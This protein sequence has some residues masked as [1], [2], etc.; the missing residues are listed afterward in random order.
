[1]PMVRLEDHGGGRLD[2]LYCKY[3]TDAQ[4]KLKSR[5]EVRK[6]MIDFAVA[7]RRKSIEDAEKFVEKF[8]RKMPAWKE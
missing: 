5:E 8:M 1:M 4:G 6:S 2:I 3:C 7:T